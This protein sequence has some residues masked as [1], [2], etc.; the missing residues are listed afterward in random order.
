MLELH[1]DTADLFQEFIWF[2]SKPTSP[3]TGL[4]LSGYIELVDSSTG[5]K[6]DS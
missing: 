3:E 5:S 1:L 2:I 4:Y 6:N